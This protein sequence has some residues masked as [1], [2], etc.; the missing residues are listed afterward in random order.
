MLGFTSINNPPIPT[1]HRIKFFPHFSFKSKTHKIPQAPSSRFIR[2]AQNPNNNNKEQEKRRQNGSSNGDDLKKDRRPIFNLKW[3]DI[4]DP[5]PDNL[6]AVGL[7]GLLAWASVQVLWQLA[8]ISL[9]I[10]VAALKYSF[11]AALLLF[12]LITLL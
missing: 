12:I 1:L 4:F 10:V 7:T 9:A 3:G 6:F 2:F 5:D 11:I 8:F